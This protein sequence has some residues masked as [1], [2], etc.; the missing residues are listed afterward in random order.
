MIDPIPKKQREKESWLDCKIWKI[1]KRSGA[2]LN[3]KW[4]IDR[5]L[6]LRWCKSPSGKNHLCSWSD[7]DHAIVEE[8]DRKKK[9]GKQIFYHFENTNGKSDNFFKHLKGDKSIKPYKETKDKYG[10]KVLHFK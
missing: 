3:S 8:Y 1:L 9:S 10:N 2:S 4:G 6:E 7:R 5:A